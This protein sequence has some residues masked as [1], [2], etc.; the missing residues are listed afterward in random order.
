MVAN[1]EG[2]GSR[3][4]DF[5]SRV[6]E[7]GSGARRNEAMKGSAVYA[8]L[9][10]VGQLLR[11]RGEAETPT[12]NQPPRVDQGRRLLGPVTL[13]ACPFA[14]L[15]SQARAHLGPGGY[16]RCS[17]NGGPQTC[18]LAAHGVPKLAGRPTHLHQQG[19]Q[20]PRGGPSLARRTMQDLL[21]NGPSRQAHEEQRYQDEANL[22][23]LGPSQGSWVLC[24]LRWAVRPAGSATPRAADRQVWGPPFPEH[25]Q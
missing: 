11:Q 4:G 19:I 6:R 5:G 8:S 15:L 3:S 24:W 16:C 7:K 21:R 23:R 1:A 25:R 20:D 9:L 22:T 17:G 14:S 18:L 12:S 13:R 10:T 2:G